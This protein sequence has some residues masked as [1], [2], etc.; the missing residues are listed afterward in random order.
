MWP[1]LAGLVVSVFTLLFA[2][3]PCC[4][5]PSDRKWKRAGVWRRH[6]A[7]AHGRRALQADP[8]AAGV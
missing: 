4:V 1:N 8:E 6:V 3:I 7:Q 5:R 2:G